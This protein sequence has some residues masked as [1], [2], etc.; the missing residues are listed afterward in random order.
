MFPTILSHI[1]VNKTCP[2]VEKAIFVWFLCGWIVFMG[3]LL[4]VLDGG[5]V[6]V[7]FRGF[8]LW[9]EAVVQL[10]YKGL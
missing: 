9:V 8:G 5:L 4:L 7:A 3:W 2:D 1:N 10:I 6:A